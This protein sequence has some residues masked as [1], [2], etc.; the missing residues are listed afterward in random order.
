MSMAGLVSRSVAGAAVAAAAAL[1]AVAP[2]QALP[3]APSPGC[4]Q[5]GAR[6]AGPAP[7]VSSV[8]VDT[9]LRDAWRHFGNTGGGWSNQGG[10]AA[11]DGTY[12]TP[13]G[14]GTIAWLYNDTFLGPVNADESLPRSAGFVH[15]SIVLGD[16]SGRPQTTVTGGTHEHPESLVG[17]T[18]TAPPYDPSGTNDRWYWNG[19]GIVD[20]GKLRE[21]ELQQGPTDGAPPFN[22]EWTGTAIATYAHDLSVESVTPT[23]GQGNVQWGAELVRCGGWTYIYGVEGVPF[24]KY[25]HIA[26]ARAGHLV[27]AWQ[28][29]TGSGWSSDPTASAR[30]LGDVGSSFSVTPVQGHYVLT[31][32]DATLG[33]EIYTYSSPSP[34]GPF[35]DRTAVYRAPEPASGIYAYN[36][37]AH[38]EIS[39]PGEL[40]LS[41]NTNAFSIDDIYA[42]AN[43]NRAR[44]IDLHF[45]PKAK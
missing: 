29:W 20:G 43:N 40:V 15:N 16:R 44:F 41:Y 25:M 31:T 19:D 9:R 27:D 4:P 42:D 2:A 18:P 23:Y 28:F 24:D 12:S 8:S 22:F 38:P 11:A 3:G 35:T 14:G 33:D 26:R 21:F 32:T 36:V 30:V 45:A 17:A 7:V 39:G 6:A 1:A 10:W 37:A 34:T 13:L 5:D